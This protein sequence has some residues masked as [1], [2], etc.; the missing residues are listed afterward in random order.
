M[1]EIEK[2]NLNTFT[3]GVTVGIQMMKNKIKSNHERGKPVMV[4]DELYWLTDS[5]EHLKDIME[6]F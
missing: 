1:E 4:D 3:L 6:H 2:E 5:K